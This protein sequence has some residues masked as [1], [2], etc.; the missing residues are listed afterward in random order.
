[1]SDTVRTDLAVICQMICN[2]VETKEIYLFGS[3]AYGEPNE[4]SDYDLCV[5][6]P[7]SN[8]RA[9]D[10]IKMI[11]RALYPI[12]TKPLDV[13]VYH[14]SNFL[15][16]QQGASLERKIVREGVLLYEYAGH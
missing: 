10:A 15:K 16:K 1:M 6:I 12:Q 7:D 4:D 13:V 5:I 9:V 3:Y 11:R 14:S 8:V 2:T